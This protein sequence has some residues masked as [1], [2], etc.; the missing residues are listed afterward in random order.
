[1]SRQVLSLG[2]STVRADGLSTRKAGQR[3]TFAARSLDQSCPGFPDMIGALSNVWN[4][5]NAR[6]TTTLNVWLKRQADDYIRASELREK[7][8]APPQGGDWNVKS[9]LELCKC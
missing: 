4:F 8:P 5:A 2:R 7:L 6:P 3:I 9:V 1:M